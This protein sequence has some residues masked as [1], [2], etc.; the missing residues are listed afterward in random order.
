MGSVDETAAQMQKMGG[1]AVATHIDHA[2]ESQNAALA[3]LISQT[4]GRLDICVNNAFYIPK[5]DMM[6]FNTPIWNQ[7]MR[8]LNEQ[9]A[10]GGL[11]HAANTLTFLPCLRRGKGVVINISSWGSQQNIGV[12]PASYLC[13]KAAFDRTS[14][15]LSEKLRSHGVYVMTLWPGSVKSERAVVGAKRSGARLT[16]LE[17][18]R[19]T[20]RAV[21]ELGALQPELLR[22]Y[23]AK[24][25]T[26][27]AADIQAWDVDGY[28][29][30]GG[31]HSFSTGGRSP[32]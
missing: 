16:D 13:N 4:H 19:F 25:R 11:N 27:S 6:F 17:S 30:Q 22:V 5:P 9:T 3:K 23:S 8:F 1:T 24:H 20:G 28:L 31:L 2:Q 10:V 15:A 18:T 21:V 32:A 7:P 29:H 14:A 26:V 12:F